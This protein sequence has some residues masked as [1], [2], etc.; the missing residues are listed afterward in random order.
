MASPCPTAV[1]DQTTPMMMKEPRMLKSRNLL[2]LCAA[3]ATALALSGC[4]GGTT[5]TGGTPDSS[6]PQTS[7]AAAAEFNFSD[8]TFAQMMIPHH[9]QAVE[10]S[11]TLLAKGGIDEQVRELATQIKD[12]QQPEIDR[13][14]EWLSEWGEEE[15]DM[16]GMNHGGMMTDEDMADLES[17]TGV[18][19]ARLFLE[20]MTVHH[21][22]A[23][24]MAE[25]E[26]DDGEN[27]DAQAMAATIVSTQTEEITQ[28][29]E[30]L[31]SL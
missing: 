2:L 5:G 4:T 23:I 29:Q 8:V 20:Q 18:E 24:A 28:M 16:G 10:M 26:V 13:L 27:A 14:R 25:A 30:L 11:D 6:E 7:E 17:A 19:A 9:E 31:A 21:E 3:A 15:A 12:A 1:V 22:G